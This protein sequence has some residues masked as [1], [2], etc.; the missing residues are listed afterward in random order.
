VGK[1]TTIG[2]RYF[3]GLHFGL[4]Y[5]PVDEFMEVRFGD[6]TAWG[7]P[8]V[9][10]S[11]Q[12]TIN[13]PQLFNGDSGEGGIEGKLDVMMGEGT[14]LANDYL[15]AI[16]G[17]AQSA[18]RGLLTLVGRHLHVAS[19]N[20]YLKPAAF[21]VRRAL[22]GWRTPVFY[23]AKAVI[24]IIVD[25]LYTIKGMNPAHVV[26]QAI[27]DPEF[28]MGFPTASIDATQFQATADDLY[29]EGF[30]FCYFWNRTS[31]VEDFLKL[32]MNHVG[33]ALV[34]DPVSGLFQF[35]LIRADYDP[36]TLPVFDESN[37]IELSEFQRA[38]ES[39]LTNEIRVTYTDPHTNRV[40]PVAPVHNLANIQ[41]QGGIVSESIDYPGCPT[42]DLANR[43]ASRD[44][45][46]RG[47]P[48]AKATI[49][50]NRTAYKLTPADVFR[51]SWAALGITHMVMRVGSV[52]YG[53]ADDPTIT[54]EAIEDVF[55]LPLTTYLGNESTGWTAPDGT[56]VASSNVLLMEAPY[57]EVHQTTDAGTF[58]TFDD[59]SCFVAGF[60]QKPTGVP[61]NVRLQTKV[62]AA[63]Y[64]DRN[65]AA[66]CPYGV[67]SASISRTSTSITLNGATSLDT[68]AVGDIGLLGSPAA[69]EIVQVTGIAANVLT[70]ARGCLDTVPHAFPAT[71][72]FFAFDRYS[73]DD[74]TEYASGETVDGRFLT[75][76]VGGTLAVG[77]APT[78][79]AT[80]NRRFGRPY[81]PGA[82]KINGTAYPGSI[83]NP[84][85]LVVSWQHRDRVTQ[86]DNVL[87]TTASS[88][89][90]EAGTTYTLQLYGDGGTLFHTETGLTGTSYTWST[91]AADSGGSLNATLRV[92]LKATR[93]GLD[94]W[95]SH[96]YTFARV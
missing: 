16:Q 67:T 69:G 54:I 78:S 2:Y 87:D 10:S 62:G 15:T 64:T 35:K 22:Q 48:L 86:A 96:D 14:Q 28:G 46:A 76:A 5:G 93:S 75:V 85:A 50:V 63:P 1:Y 47:T 41:A 82:L 79:S 20:P 83:P 84:D 88:V 9:T 4:C 33:G 13:A 42:A 72:Q 31:S 34:T 37:I 70:I 40:V 3:M 26:Y 59:D 44:L 52:N 66:W 73:A 30:A 61:L 55:G 36:A 90:P 43:L 32:V 51:F 89:G 18:F 25:L 49:K 53:T 71:T 17:G 80:M 24:S 38:S 58:A 7:G 95:Q 56:P 94:S 39:G 45:A 81:P 92:V 29:T 65:T 27:T 74:V 12:I 11:G 68:L 91:E 6:L 21:K 60:A 77:S 57:R 19:I 8:S 23:S